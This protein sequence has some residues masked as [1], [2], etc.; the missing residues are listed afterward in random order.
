[1]REMAGALMALLSI[2]TV[3]AR[4]ASLPA[5]D[6]GAVKGKPCELRF[7]WNAAELAAGKSPFHDEILNVEFRGPDQTTYLIRPFWDGGRMVRARFTPNLGGKWNY[8]VTSEIKR[9]EV[10]EASFTAADNNS[11][12]FVSVANVRHWWTADKQPH[13]W[14]SAEAPWLDLDDSG[15]K[16]FVDARKR[17]GFTHLRGV[18]LTRAAGAGPLD[19]N[20]HPNFAYFTK[21][22][23]RLLYANDQGLVLDLILADSAFVQSGALD[24][25]E[26]R[27]ALIRYVI[28]RYAVLN[29]S[30]QGFEH[31]EDRPGN[32]N[33]LKEMAD[34]LK[35][36]DQFHHAI[37]TDAGMTSSVLLADGWEN[38]IIEASPNPQLAAVDRQFTAEP[39]IHVIQSVEPDAF[40]RE[41]WHSTTNGEYPTMRYQAAQNP[42]NIEAMKVW[43]KVMSDVR[44]WEFEPFFDVDG[45]RAVGLNNVEYLLY[46]D[47]PGTVEIDF[48]EKHKYNPRWINPRTGETIELKNAKQDS[49]SQTTP[50]EGGDWI[51][52]VPREGH[53]EGMLKSY[54]FESA[55]APVQ[56]IE[57]NPDKVPFE[58]LQPQGEEIDSTKPIAYEIKMKRANRATRLMQY[59]WIGE[60]VADG[61]GPR[62]LALGGSGTCEFPPNLIK[63]RPAIL[64]LRLNAINANGK[65]Y[66]VEKAYQI[67]K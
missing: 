14:C 12:G 17:D 57:L 25:W 21:L 34:L 64:N 58:I 38:Y 6:G 11:P 4:G 3:A 13:L 52:Q 67:S 5:C 29:V 66:S 51:L 8:R 22:D 19:G 44:H 20:G 62:V 36:Y 50:A 7:E 18:V 28:S 26:Q 24:P 23:D 27:D 56:E 16:A 61:E 54:K 43:I 2:A 10:R 55:D 48:S 39:Q 65:A 40:R 35:R 9:L 47:K 15:F 45:A 32:R 37:S 1:M 30:W 41:L 60:V 59:V 46:A 42:S 63:K 33:L 31:F 49:Y 53:K